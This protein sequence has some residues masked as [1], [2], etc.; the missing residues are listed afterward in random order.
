MAM[1]GTV[2][3]SA[4]ALVIAFGSGCSSCDS[5]PG[6]TY[7]QRNI[8]P[9]LIGSCS[10]GTSGCHAVNTDD[11]HFF[12]AGN[13]DV[14]SF[15]N[16]QKRR[17][18]L[19]RFGPYPQP[20]L[21]IKAIAPS[22]PDPAATGRLQFQYGLAASDPTG[23]TPAFRDI[24]VLHAGGQVID[25]NSDAYFTLQTWLENGATENG[26]KPPTPA[27]TGNGTCSTAIPSGFSTTA[28]MTNPKYGA[29]LDSFKSN[30]MPIL[31]AHGC[32]SSNCHGAPQSDFYITCG[33][34]DEELAFNFTQAW[35][36]V[37]NPVD[38]SQI[39]RVPLAVSAGGRGHTGGDQ[40]AGTDDS[41]FNKI[42]DW[43]SSS[44][45]SISRTAIRS[46]STSRTTSSRSCCSAR[47]SRSRRCHSP[48][49]DERLQVALGHAGLL[50]GSLALEKNYD[51]LRNEFIALE[52]PDSYVA[53]APIAKNAVARWISRT[54]SGRRHRASRWARSSRRPGLASDPDGTTISADVALL[55][56]PRR[57]ARR[58]TASF[59]E[60]IRHRARG[61][62]RAQVSNM[63]ADRSRCRS[64]TSRSAGRAGCRSPRVRH[65]PGR[66]GSSRRSPMTFTGNCGSAAS[67]VDND[68]G[69]ATSLL[70]DVRGA[71]RRHRRR[72][73]LPSVEER[74][75]RASRSPRAT[76]ATAAAL[77]CGSSSIDGQELH[78]RSTPA[79][80]RFERHQ[81]A[82]L[83][84]GVGAGRQARSYSRRRAASPERRDRDPRASGSCRSRICGASP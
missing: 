47:L 50:L 41:D 9:I 77:G 71:H 16:V 74:R 24:E 36:F 57:R 27:Q 49:G 54:T 68:D 83:R 75:R 65:L 70:G 80:R 20:L 22:L 48:A 6:Q 42:R 14:T 62:S 58:R 32:T 43:A 30:V 78:A 51:L 2:C 84:S 1:K 53:V 34:T 40:F 19:T 55:S 10:K 44:G 81:G 29:G 26:L 67:T 61:R 46:S 35:S 79:R 64:S 69:G 56:R 23:N 4:L 37:N 33:D 73:G 8:E 21:L 45:C 76:S 5:P 28:L 31:K 12:A 82:R 52:F 13:F 38:D 17:D 63:N 3:A 39:L 59:Q 18:A 15:E 72:P 66:R 7:Y 25:I 11:A 60:W